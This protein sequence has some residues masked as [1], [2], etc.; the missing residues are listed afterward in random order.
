[1][2]THE[3]PA[4]LVK[5]FPDLPG[6][7]VTELPRRVRLQMVPFPRLLRRWENLSRAV[8]K[9]PVNGRRAGQG[10]AEAMPRKRARVLANEHDVEAGVGHFD[11]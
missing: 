11:G 7:I 1:M 4:I 2:H 6:S 8:A 5:A 10:S 3:G 9:H